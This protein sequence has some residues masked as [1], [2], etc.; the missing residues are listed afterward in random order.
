[1][2]PTA[3]ISIA[4]GKISSSNDT[5]F[6]NCTDFGVHLEGQ[7]NF[8]GAVPACRH[9]LGHQPDLLPRRHA[10]L[11]TPGQTE[12]TNFEIAVGIQ[13]KVSR[14]KVTVNNISAV[15]RFEGTEC[16]VYEILLSWSIK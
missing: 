4:C 5:V 11:H 9:I 13:E 2:Q 16:L 7:H 15:D 12:V 6:A 10:R 14:F 1:M 8:R 3:Q